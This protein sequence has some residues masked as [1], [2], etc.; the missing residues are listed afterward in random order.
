MR[1][2]SK[3]GPCRSRYSKGS[4]VGV[5]TVKV[6]PYQSSLYSKVRTCMSLYSKGGPFRSLYSKGGHVGICTVR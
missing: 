2:Y 5:C 1:L 3:G 6:G 4:H